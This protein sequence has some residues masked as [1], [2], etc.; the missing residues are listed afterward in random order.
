VATILDRGGFDRV[1]EAVGSRSALAQCLQVVKRDGRINL[2]GIAPE[3]EPYWAH[4]VDDPRVFRGPVAEAEEHERLLEWVAEGLV[5]LAQ[6]I[7]HE[8]PWTD[9]ESGFELVT[10]KRANKVVLTFG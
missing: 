10:Q 8:M 4:Q 6:W 5:D 2:Y 3:S 9:Y 1:I 7:S